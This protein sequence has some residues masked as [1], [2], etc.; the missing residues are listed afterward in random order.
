MVPAA[1]AEQRAWH[2]VGTQEILVMIIIIT[3]ITLG[4]EPSVKALSVCGT[5]YA[6]Y[7]NLAVLPLVHF[8]PPQE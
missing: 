6:T 4:S 2:R 7:A 1:S 8:I 5:A 3:T